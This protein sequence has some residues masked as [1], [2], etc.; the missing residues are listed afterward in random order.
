MS[1]RMHPNRGTRAGRGR[2]EAGQHMGWPWVPHTASPARPQSWRAHPSC[3]VPE[4]WGGEVLTDLH[5]S[6][7]GPS[8]VPHWKPWTMLSFT[9]PRRALST[10]TETRELLSMLLVNSSGFEGED[11]HTY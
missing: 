6:Q 9:E 10:C 4:N 8:R 2:E 11:M 5:S 7:R 3:K 1:V